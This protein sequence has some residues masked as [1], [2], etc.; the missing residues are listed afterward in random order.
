LQPSFAETGFENPFDSPQ[1][2]GRNVLTTMDR[3]DGL[4]ASRATNDD[5]RATLTDLNAP[6]AFDD[7]HDVSPS[8]VS[9]VLDELSR[10]DL[11]LAQ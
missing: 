2:A 5:M 9:T 3:D 10:N 1:S 8:H 4:A 11:R 7:P 6:G